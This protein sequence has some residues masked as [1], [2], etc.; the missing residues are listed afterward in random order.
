MATLQASKIRQ[1]SKFLISRGAGL[2]SLFLQIFDIDMWTYNGRL[3][4]SKVPKIIS[5]V[6]LT[7]TPG[8]API[9]AILS[10]FKLSIIAS[11]KYWFPE[12]DCKKCRQ[13]HIP[14]LI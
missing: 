6:I 13:K 2:L 4:D 11:S 1:Y 12:I 7:F 5:E 14:S 8:M 10:S 3:V 9:H